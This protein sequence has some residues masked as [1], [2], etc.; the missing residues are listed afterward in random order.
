MLR[1]LLVLLLATES[2]CL[3]A[4]TA[5]TAAVIMEAPLP[6]SDCGCVLQTVAHSR[7][8][9]GRVPEQPS[10]ATGERLWTDADYYYEDHVDN[11]WSII[12]SVLLN[13]G[14]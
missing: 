13:E 1:R 6:T 9:R 8:K 3:F 2:L 4:A 10:R 5:A 11:V 14:E 7:S 12:I